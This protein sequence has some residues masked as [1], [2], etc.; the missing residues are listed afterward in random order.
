MQDTLLVSIPESE[1]QRVCKSS[2][3]SRSNLQIKMAHY[4]I[5]IHP[6]HDPMAVVKEEACF[7]KKAEKDK[8]Y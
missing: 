1:T 8:V 3:E 4:S 7:K 6:L 5:H 2:S